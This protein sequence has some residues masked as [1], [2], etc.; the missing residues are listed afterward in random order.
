V[1]VSPRITGELE[2]IAPD[3]VRAGEPMSRHTSFG[4]GGA[5]DLFLAPSNG[6]ALKDCLA[7]LASEGVPVV[8]LGKGTNILVRDGGIDGAVLA[9]ER[10]FTDLVRTDQ[11][12]SVGSGAT[13]SRVL[14]FC[15]EEGLA[16]IEALAGI[17]GTIGGGVVTN[18]GSFGVSLGD[19]VGS[20]AFFR[21]GAATTTISGGELGAAYRRTDLPEGAVVESVTLVL[22][23]DE[24]E[25]ILERRDRTLERK[26][27][28]QP[29]GMRSAGCIFKNPPGDAAGR[30]I[31]SAGLKGMRIGGAVVSDVHANYILNDRGAT[32]A[33]VEELIE[34]VR[35]R[36]LEEAGVELELEVEIIGRRAD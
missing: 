10:A 13:L 9:T 19:R 26:W 20:V 24:S 22:D 6:P 3:D 21:A 8:V 16:G 29:A 2:A 31:D 23:D 4:L 35:A 27:R 7:L 36:V 25:R 30:L 1:E 12:L 17:P 15:I 34:L 11:G 33:D 32:A 18:A 14:T 28:A 5:A